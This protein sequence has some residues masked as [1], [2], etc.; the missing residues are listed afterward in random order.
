LSAKA[1][2]PLFPSEQIPFIIDVVL[3]YSQSLHKKHATEKEDDLSDRLHKR[4]RRDPRIRTAPFSIHREYRVYDNDE[5]ADESGY[6]GRIDFNFVCPGG[7]E[8]YF[9]IE[10]KRLH[11]SFPSGY[12]TLIDEYVSGDQ[13]MMCF[14]NR[15]YSS[16]QHAGAMLGYVFDGDINK[17]RKGIKSATSKQSK[18]L[19][20]LSPPGFKKSTVV[21]RT[22]RVDETHHDLGRRKFHIYHI[23]TAV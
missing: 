14:I 15:K 23:L 7:D 9:A 22:E 20:L 19:K 8:T 11:V 18:K 1:F 10:A 13:G 5:D 12:K 4:I 6:S 16:A 21:K 3:N 2:I 17:A